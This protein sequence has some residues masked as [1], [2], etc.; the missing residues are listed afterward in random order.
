MMAVLPARKLMLRGVEVLP[1][2]VGL[3]LV[4]MGLPA[5]PAGCSREWA[6]R[7]LPGS[8]SSQP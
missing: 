3:A 4:G 7:P 5:I 1:W 2:G 8:C 6:C